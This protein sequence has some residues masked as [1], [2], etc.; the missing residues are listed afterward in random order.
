LEALANR[1]VKDIEDLG[2]IHKIA[3][4]D[5]TVEKW[6]LIPLHHPHANREAF[7]TS[8]TTWQSFVELV[9]WRNEYA[10]PKAVVPDVRRG[11]KTAE[12]LW[13]GDS[14]LESS[15]I[16]PRI[17]QAFPILAG[18]RVYANSQLPTSPYDVI[19]ENAKAGQAIVD[20]MTEK[21][22]ELLS[23]RLTAAKLLKEDDQAFVFHPDGTVQNR[24]TTRGLG[25][26]DSPGSHSEGSPQPDSEAT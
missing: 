25:F 17:R 2:Q 15:E 4:K 3:E 1:V 14:V 7:D 22:D 16:P 5:S 23:G 24:E 18:P 21:L 19:Y 8:S 6:K 26:A 10:H 9:K 20:R 13:T 12:G 11:R